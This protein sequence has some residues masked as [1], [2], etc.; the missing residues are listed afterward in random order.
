MMLG[1]AIAA[2]ILGIVWLVEAALIGGLAVASAAAKVGSL[3]CERCNGW[4]D[5]PGQTPQLQIAE[6]SQSILERVMVGEVLALR[7]MEEA[8]SNESVF[9]VAE[10][11]C[12]HKCRQ[13]NT[14]T[15]KKVTLSTDDKGNEQRKEEAIFAH[16]LITLEERKKLLEPWGTERAEP[17][18]RKHI[19]DHANVPEVIAKAIA[20]EPRRAMS[21]ALAGPPA[22]AAMDT[23]IAAPPA[24]V[25]PPTP[26]EPQLPRQINTDIAGPPPPE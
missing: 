23:G 24:Q 4:V 19:G 5:E 10:S 25:E 3:F 22:L 13:L 8:L 18:V 20:A 2:L 15:V 17:E 21:T 12:C 1:G 26:V 16:M 6:N 9:L 11:S 7:E 14:L